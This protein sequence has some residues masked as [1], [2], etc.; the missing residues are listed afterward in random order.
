MPENGHDAAKKATCLGEVKDDS[1]RV[2]RLP[3]KLGSTSHERATRAGADDLIA[4]AIA[5]T[6]AP[7][8]GP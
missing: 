3:L 2:F 8:R 5:P 7:G 6:S 1:T 4:I